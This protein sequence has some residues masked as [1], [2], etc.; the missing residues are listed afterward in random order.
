MRD[1]TNELC[2]AIDAAIFSGDEFLNAY[3]RKE[4]RD[5]MARWERGLKEHEEATRW[6]IEEEDHDAGAA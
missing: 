3:A 1:H 6:V 2:D 5:Y 4:L